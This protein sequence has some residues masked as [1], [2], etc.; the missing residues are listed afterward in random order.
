M[1][2]EA[3]TSGEQVGAVVNTALSLQTESTQQELNKQTFTF[4][5]LK[6]QNG[7]I[8]TIYFDCFETTSQLEGK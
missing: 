7:D 2:A 1:R 4:I 8:L 6:K 3:L 5:L